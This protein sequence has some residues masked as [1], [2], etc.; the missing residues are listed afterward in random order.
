KEKKWE[1]FCEDLEELLNNY[2]ELLGILETIAVGEKGEVNEAIRGLDNVTQAFLV[3]YDKDENKMIDAN[4]L[5]EKKEELARDLD[6]GEESQLKKIVEA[7]HDLKR[8]VIGYYKR[9][10]KETGEIENQLEAQLT[11]AEEK[12][13]GKNDKI[14]IS[15]TSSQKIKQ[16]LQDWWTDFKTKMNTPIQCW[17][18]LECCGQK[19]KDKG[20]N[21]AVILEEKTSEQKGESSLQ[22]QIEIPPNNN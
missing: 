17:Y 15:Q 5:K 1:G 10:E 4:E 2:H 13:N 8:E 3:E 7:I 9:N 18:C 21:K 20:K 11:K 6:K 12:N 16:D 22:A 14:I 19:Q